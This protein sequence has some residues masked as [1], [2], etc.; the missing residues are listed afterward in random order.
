M[1][2]EVRFLVLGADSCVDVFFL[3]LPYFLSIGVLDSEVLT[4]RGDIIEPSGLWPGS[5]AL[6]VPLIGPSTEGDS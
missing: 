5:D 4:N 2:P 3:F 6:D 1:T